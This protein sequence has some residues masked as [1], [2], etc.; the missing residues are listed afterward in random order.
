MHT[1]LPGAPASVRPLRRLTV[2][3]G[4]LLATLMTVAACTSAA[5]ERPAATP[6]LP[7]GGD[8]LRTS[9]QAMA[10]V[11]SVGFTIETEG[12]PP[13]PVQHAE[14]SLTKEADAQGTIRMN[15]FGTLQE[16]EF[17]LIGDKVHFKG[18]TGGYQTMTREQLA[19]L[20]DPSAILNPDKGVSHLLSTAGTPKTEAEEDVDGIPAYRVAAQLSQPV[21]AALIPGVDQAVNAK[22]WVD[23]ATS[24]LLKASLPLGDGPTAGTVTVLFTD[25]DKPIKITAPAS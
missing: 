10:A 17:V 20:Y 3:L 24:R 25:Y 2:A 16:M 22:L 11:K 6:A 12:K 5:P 14:G 23:T 7:D 18:P 21:V 1:S 19:A 13:V 9:A 8:L 4:W 15:V